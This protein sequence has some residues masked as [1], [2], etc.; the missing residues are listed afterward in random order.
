MDVAGPPAC[1]AILFPF[2]IEYA[3]PNNAEKLLGAWHLS[4]WTI[5]YSDGRAPTL[6]FGESVSGLLIY[7]EDGYMS[8]NIARAGR[9]P[10]AS[11]SARMAP[12]DEKI[13]AFDSFFSYAGTY[14]VAGDE[15]IHYVTMALFANLV[16][17]EQRRTMRFS[18]EGLEL[19]A[20]DLLPGS[21]VK[22]THQLQWRR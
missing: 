11:E 16:G 22:R 9:Q 2:R 5:T 4:R 21:T 12:V 13:R 19:S 6:P 10:L 17:T 8:G 7:S 20:V 18:E 15:V 1:S 14:E 3:M